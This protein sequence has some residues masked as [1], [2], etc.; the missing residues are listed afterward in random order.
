M[1]TANWDV[2]N[3]NSGT[4]GIRLVKRLG[5][6]SIELQK[7]NSESGSGQMVSSL[8]TVVYYNGSSGHTSYVEAFQ[9]SGSSHNV[10]GSTAAP[11]CTFNVYRL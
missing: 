10:G 3:G 5:V 9:D 8:H 11:G 6:A 7:I 4:R 1:A 2:F